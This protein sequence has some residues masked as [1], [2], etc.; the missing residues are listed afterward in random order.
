MSATAAL[1]TPV[2]DRLLIVRDAA[3]KATEG[4][5]VLPEKAVEKPQ[6]GV[7]VAVGPGARDRDGQRIPLTITEG[8]RVLFSAYADVVEIDDDEFV[9]LREDE[10]YAVLS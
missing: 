8:D 7:V 6:Q 4:G 10:V 5:I 3:K 1:C 9:I 2:N